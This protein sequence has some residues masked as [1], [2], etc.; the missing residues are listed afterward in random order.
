MRGLMMDVPLLVSRIIDYAADAHGD[1]AVVARTLEGGVFRYDYAHARARAKRLA[2][3]LGRLGVRMGD[4]V[5]SLAWSTHHHLDLFYGVSGMGAVLHT[6]NPRLAQD[7]LV[8]MIDHAADAYLFVD[9]ET[10]AIAE[11]IEPRLSSVRGYVFM[12]T[13]ERLPEARL[14]NLCSYETLLAVQ[15]DE[16]DWPEFDERSASTLCYTSGTTGDPK[17][18][19]YSHRAATLSALAYSMADALGGYREGALDVLMP[20][21]PMYHGNAWQ[22]PYTA[23]MNGHKLVLPGRNFEPEKLYELMEAEGV[24]VAAGVPAVWQMLVEHLDRTGQRFSTLR[25]AFMSGSQPSAALL[26]ALE[27]RHGVRVAQIWGMTEAPATLKG[28]LK[29]GLADAPL[30]ERVRRKLKQG[31]L[32]FGT[33]FRIVDDAGRTLPHD[34]KAVGRLMVRGPWIASNYYRH[35]EA[36]QTD[37]DWL[38]T[39]DVA[40]V[41]PD[42]CVEVTD[43]AKDVIKSGG[44]WISSVALEHAAAG[45]PDVL[46]VAVIAIPHPKWQERPLMLIVRRPG[47]AAGADEIRR[48]LAATVASWWLP[49]AIL[50]VDELPVTAT[51]KVRKSVLRERYRDYRP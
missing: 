48:H 40:V 25:A 5:G 2:R 17:G 10:L 43:R 19:L 18:V 13:T 21:T 38:D 15:T 39:G 41:H 20:I 29:P 27:G 35:D 32:S 4:R 11:A 6:A 26:E 9:A 31:R 44:E 1:T 36:G 3:A 22:M 16:Y 50:F 24:T 12:G 23:P 14:E 7:Q 45:H 42:G 37:F 8:Y 33:S 47:A 34:G 51:G 30:R 28:T 49:D 46:G